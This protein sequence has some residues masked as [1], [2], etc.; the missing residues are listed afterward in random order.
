MQGKKKEWVKKMMHDDDSEDDGSNI[1]GVEKSWLA[2]FSSFSFANIVSF[3]PPLL[4]R[5]NTPTSVSSPPR[6]RR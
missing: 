4:S 2:S 5:T 1:E 6:R 3:V